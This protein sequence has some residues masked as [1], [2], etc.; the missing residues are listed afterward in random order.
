[1][2]S[3]L[4][5]SLCFSN[6]RLTGCGWE[7]GDGDQG[8]SDNNQFYGSVAWEC[9]VGQL[10]DGHMQISLER[11]PTPQSRSSLCTNNSVPG[12][13]PHCGNHWRTKSND[14]Q[15]PRACTFPFSSHFFPS[16]SNSPLDPDLRTLTFSRPPPPHPHRTHAPSSSPLCI[17]SP[18]TRWVVYRQTFLPHTIALLVADVPQSPIS[19]NVDQ[20]RTTRIT[21]SG[22]ENASILSRRKCHEDRIL[23][24]GTED[25]GDRW[26]CSSEESTPGWSIEKVRTL[27]LLSGPFPSFYLR[28]PGPLFHRSWG[29]G[30][31]LHQP[32]S[33]G[34]SVDDPLVYMASTPAS[35]S[36]VPYL[37]WTRSRSHPPMRDSTHSFWF[38][39]IGPHLANVQS[40]V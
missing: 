21:S 2:L 39:R 29:V 7:Q 8:E 14:R 9:G 17:P 5:E 38:S 12:R 32:P 31:F 36:M 37:L 27:R 11:I 22:R 25:A 18:T 19:A 30:P 1:M 34:I 20:R 10:I 13:V 23:A 6:M 35:P 28:C 40:S 15:M 26:I 3:L 33:R 24:Q 16:P 4:C